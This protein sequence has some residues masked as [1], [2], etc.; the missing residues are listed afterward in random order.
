MSVARR[1][2]IERRQARE[3]EFGNRRR[4]IGSCRH[5]R[6]H[7]GTAAVLRRHGISSAGARSGASRSGVDLLARPALRRDHRDRK[8]SGSLIRRPFAPRAAG[9]PATSGSARSRLRLKNASLD[10]VLGDERRNHV[11]HRFRH[12]H[13]LDEIVAGLGQAFAFGRIGGHRRT[14]HR[15]AR[16]RVAQHHPQS[17]RAG[18]R[19]CRDSCRSRCDAARRRRSRHRMSR[20]RHRRAS[21]R[22]RRRLRL[23]DQHRD[24]PP[25]DNRSTGSSAL[26]RSTT[27][28]TGIGS[29]RARSRHRLQML[30]RQ[31]GR[32]GSA[33]S[34]A[35]PCPASIA[36]IR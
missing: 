17:R 20:A 11:A 12:R 34:C 30:D 2:R 23:A 10:M 13:R 32:P 16:R 4:L 7:R 25:D 18:S 14:A 28:P 33:A 27:T 21:M 1:D 15:A 3:V 8:L 6:A 26:P 29:E 36:R 19:D 5:P 35:A 24:R 31:A 9:V 22:P